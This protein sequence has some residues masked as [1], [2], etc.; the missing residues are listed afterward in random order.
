VDGVFT[1]LTAAPNE[2]APPPYGPIALLAA[3]IA[4]REA[5]RGDVGAE[6]D[7]LGLPD[8]AAAV[9]KEVL[10]DAKD[11]RIVRELMD[12]APEDW[13]TP[14]GLTKFTRSF[15]EAFGLAA[16]HPTEGAT[17]ERKSLDQTVSASSLSRPAATPETEISTES[18]PIQ[19]V[20]QEHSPVPSLFRS[21]EEVAAPYRQR[22]AD[23][24]AQQ[25]ALL[26]E[27]EDNAEHRKRL[28]DEIVRLT[29]RQLEL[30]GAIK[31]LEEKADASLVEE[32]AARGEALFGI[33]EHAGAELLAT[34]ATW[35]KTRANRAEAET[36]LK[37]KPDLLEQFKLLD[38][39]EELKRRRVLES[40]PNG[41]RAAV[42]NSAHAA[43]AAVGSE[44]DATQTA[45]L[46]TTNVLPVALS[47][48]I[49]DRRIRIGAG[50]PLAGADLPALSPGGL[51][52]ALASALTRAMAQTLTEA[53]ANRSTAE[54]SHQWG[55]T[56]SV[57][58]IEAPLGE[59][60]PAAESRQDEALL[61]Q[62]RVEDAVKQEVTLK[63]TGI[64]LQLH[65]VDPELLEEAE[66]RM[67]LVVI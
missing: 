44:W 2:L 4:L 39:Y 56:C 66:E 8:R 32:R 13:S 11:N 42:E 29:N 33:L 63:N 22:R 62:I 21:L 60:A 65:L 3:A 55:E 6:V 30:D 41:V 27:Q 16:A 40:L 52:V 67:R 64:S 28:D 20:T 57:L 50:L 48:S 61:Y 49:E 47:L 36:K 26:D 15:A 17:P 38:E 45:S 7:S 54:V 37:S 14:T 51:D 35:D 25:K 5:F 58:W 24:L 46:D 9:L 43:R 19:A 34:S 18:G 10:N 59:G 1:T 31:D 23:V 12:V 53:A